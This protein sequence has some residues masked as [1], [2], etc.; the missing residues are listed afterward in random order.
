MNRLLNWLIAAYSLEEDRSTARLLAIIILSSIIG[1]LAISVATFFNADPVS[2]VAL[3]ITSLVLAFVLVF[4]RAGRLGLSRWL[5]PLIALTIVS[6]EVYA[7]GDGTKE[8]QILGYPIIIVFATLLLGSRGAWVFTLLS[9]ASYTAILFINKYQLLRPFENADE[10][11]PLD[12]IVATIILALVAVTVTTIVN[13]LSASL[14]RLRENQAEL[15]TTIQTLEDVQNNLERLVSERTRQIETSAEVGRIASSILDV[16]ALIHRVVDLITNQFGYYYAAIF[17]VDE[18]NLWANLKAAS[19]EA[20]RVLLERGHRL[21]V[22][23]RSM[24]G[25][26]IAT[27][28]PRIAL[29]AGAE[30]VRFNNPLLPETRSEIALPLMVGS[31]VLGALDV[32]SVE[33]SAFDEEDIEV[34]QNMANQLGV[35]I[36]NARLFQE[37]QARLNELNRLYRREF[38]IP[39]R[40]IQYRN[41]QILN[42]SPQ[43]E[44]L[45]Q[46]LNEKDTIVTHTGNHT[47]VVLPFLSA[48]QVVGVMSLKSKNR[49][50][51][52]E[53]IALLESAAGQVS[54]ALENALLIRES[55]ERARQERALSAGAARIRET[56]DIEAI[57]QTAA[58]EMQRTLNLLEVEVQV[59]LA[60]AAPPA[61]DQ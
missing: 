57:L 6:Y 53:E 3:S 48:G 18:N 61:Q 49:R 47:R 10:L 39:S 31:R 25:S 44:A 59:G 20:G 9:S 11:Q 45:E 54:T 17:L 23:G 29:D 7:I 38:Q 43:I 26:A 14:A 35:A 40:G 15:R 56:L 42:A 55:Q 37:S 52:A 2:S 12:S 30:A 1:L 58:A 8:V 46:A 5:V 32:Q 13:R 19:G 21:Q 28:Q 34:L 50:W 41:G 51:T 27:H 4:L 60:P 16:D 33:G 36:E 24:V 22:G